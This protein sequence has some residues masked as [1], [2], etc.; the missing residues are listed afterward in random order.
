MLGVTGRA[1]AAVVG[2]V[3]AL[4]SV[5]AVAR[6]EVRVH[7][8]CYLESGPVECRALESAFY[9]SMGSS[10]GRGARD[11]DVALRVRAVSLATSVH[12]EIGS[13]AGTERL[14]L[15]DS[16]PQ[17]LDGDATLLRVVSLLERGTL[18]FLPLAGAHAGDDGELRLTTRDA[19]R[20]APDDGEEQPFYLRPSVSG[21]L[22][23]QGASMISL[24]ARLE[25]SWSDARWRVLASG[26]AAYRHLRI[27]I[28]GAQRLEGSAW[29]A[30]APLV[31]ARTIAGGL[32]VAALAEVA[33]AP[34][35]NL[36]RSVSAGGGVEWI[37][38]PIRRDE[39]SNYGARYRLLAVSHDYV[40]P[41]LWAEGDRLF[42]RHSL[43]A[44]VSWHTDALDL[45]LDASGSMVLDRPEAWDV[46]GEASLTW[47]VTDA[48]EV[49]VH[50][51]ATYRGRAVNEPADPDGLDPIAVVVSGSDFGTMS[52][53]GEL[54]L[55]YTFG[56]GLMH[57]RDQRWK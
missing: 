5:G 10:V 15:S 52:F 41:N 36:D 37:R 2:F 38:V 40:T 57:A 20:A 25:A 21:E 33:R 50:S 12:Y 53:G 54:E 46:G 26:R 19:S 16:V 6:A 45:A 23:S 27:D 39:E 17:A 30:S 43:T 8:D 48:L 32:S 11:A 14:S 34:Q 42:A 22:V 47:R 56:N 7:I 31:I 44:F 4:V 55:S 3:C 49:T 24:G 28:P 9:E 1:S 29:S 51:W 13:T 35:N 18:P